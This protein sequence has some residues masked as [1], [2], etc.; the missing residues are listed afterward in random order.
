MDND[1]IYRLGDIAGQAQ[2]QFQAAYQHIDPVIGLNRQLRQQGFA[3]DIMTIDCN[4][5]K[6]RITLL[7]D[8]KTPHSA[9]FQFGQI[10]QDPAAQFTPIALSALNQQGFYDLMVKGLVP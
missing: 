6:Q 5:S 4:T 8:D 7:I 9:G 1:L 2:A 10:D 3:V